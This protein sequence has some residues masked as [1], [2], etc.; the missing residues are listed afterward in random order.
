M[1]ALAKT[2]R[3]AIL[4]AALARVA[5]DGMAALSLRSLAADVGIATNALYHYFETRAHLETAL[6][7]AAG[8]ALLDALEHGLRRRHGRARIQALGKA[9]V[10]FARAQPHLYALFSTAGCDDTVDRPHHRALWDLVIAESTLLHGEQRAEAAAT[11]LWA[12][13]HGTVALH[14]AGMLEGT[15][16]EQNIQFGL[17]AWIHA[18]P[19]AGSMP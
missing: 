19:A 8:G 7:D 1:P 3:D 11:S 10:A 13:L 12:L 5:E 17:E 2:G 16:P 4:K 6:S 15:K 9:Y 18:S 14:S